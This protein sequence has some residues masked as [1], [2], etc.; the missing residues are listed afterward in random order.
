[1]TAIT[2]ER[3]SLIS[4]SSFDILN[5]HK[6]HSLPNVDRFNTLGIPENLKET[7]KIFAMW[8]RGNDLIFKIELKKEKSFV[9]LIALKPGSPKFQ[10][11]EVWYKL[12]PDFWNKGYATEALKKIVQYGFK[13]LRLHRIEA[14]CAVENFG[15]IKVLEKVPLPDV[16][17]LLSK[18]EYET[19]DMNRFSLLMNMIDLYLEPLQ[20]NLNNDE[21]ILE[22]E[23][24][25]NTICPILIFGHNDGNTRSPYVRN[26]N[27]DPKPNLNQI[28]EGPVT[29][30]TGQSSKFNDK[31]SNNIFPGDIR[32]HWDY[33]TGISNNEESLQTP[34][35]QIHQLTISEELNGKGEIIAEEIPYLSFFMP[36]SMFR[37]SI[38]AVQR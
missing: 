32:I 31:N 13:E 1:M 27:K 8:L 23:K 21:W 2:S 25:K 9:G 35:L 14:G 3:L 26:R 20:E 7:E 16:L 28:K 24:R 29:S 17:E 6:L 10:K 5:I 36:R 22:K 33:L 38:S 18:F 11:A 15:S 4:I 34:T 19:R 12:H 37:D 30:Q